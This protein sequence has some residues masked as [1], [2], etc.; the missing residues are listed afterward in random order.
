MSALQTNKGLIHIPDCAGRDQTL[1][2]KHFSQ[3]LRMK[4]A[5]KRLNEV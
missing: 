1:S 5:E 2:I 3:S 4:K